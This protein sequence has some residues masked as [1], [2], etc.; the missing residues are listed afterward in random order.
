MFHTTEVMLSRNNIHYL[1]GLWN[2]IQDLYGIKEQ[3]S[4][5]KMIDFLKK[6]IYNHMVLYY[7]GSHNASID[8]YML[9]QI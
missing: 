3:N 9:K 4:I 2:E 5:E 7:D 6:K 8:E 1:S